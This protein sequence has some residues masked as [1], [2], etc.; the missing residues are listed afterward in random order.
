MKS[1]RRR[2][3][4][5]RALTV[6]NAWWTGLFVPRPSSKTF[7]SHRNILGGLGSANMPFATMGSIVRPRLP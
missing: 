3:D 7:C 6:P 4:P 1:C 5:I 2:T